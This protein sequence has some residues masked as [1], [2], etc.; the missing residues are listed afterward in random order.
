MLEFFFELSTSSFVRDI[1]GTL[2]KV[3]NFAFIIG[4]NFVSLAG[5]HYQLGA[6][7][8]VALNPICNLAVVDLNINRRLPHNQN[9][10]VSHLL[11]DLVVSD[12]ADDFIGVAGYR[13]YLVVS[14]LVIHRARVSLKINACLL[15]GIFNRLVA[16][17]ELNNILRL[18]LVAIVHAHCCISF[19]LSVSYRQA[20]QVPAD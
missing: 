18:K 3:F 15:D 17:A 4:G 1:V 2:A 10:L 5:L 20:K 9:H 7:V 14:K 6:F 12:F 8:R 11:S 13:G 19:K 16:C